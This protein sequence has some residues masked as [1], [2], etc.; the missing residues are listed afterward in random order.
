MK[1]LR[2]VFI[3]SL[4]FSCVQHQEK[5][6]PI[7]LQS[8]PQECGPVCLQMVSEYYGVSH[9]IQSLNE[10]SKLDTEEGTSMGNIAEAADAIGMETLAVKIDYA[11]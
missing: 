11:T 6:F 8:L 4:C 5:P 10:L 3:L 2:L 7:K 9:S 1:I